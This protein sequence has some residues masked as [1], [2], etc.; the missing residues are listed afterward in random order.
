MEYSQ[1]PIRI[2]KI[3]NTDNMKNQGGVE[4]TGALIA[5]GNARWYSHFGDNLKISYKAKHVV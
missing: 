5:G 1:T 2:V 3:Q 4:A